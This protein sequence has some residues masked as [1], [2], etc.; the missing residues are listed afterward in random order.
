VISGFVLVDKPGGWTSHDVVGK[1]RRL[2]GQKKVGHA[3]TL[4]PMATGLVVVGLGACTRLM[5]YVQDQPKTYEAT[6]RFGVATDS[7]DADGTEVERHPMPVS[8]GDV[9]S[10]LDRF[11]GDIMQ[12]PPMVSAL[13]KDGRRLH[14]L[15]REGKVVE[16]RPRPVTIHDLELTG[17]VEGDYPD[18]SFR[19]TCGSGTYV[20]S[21][22]DDIAAEL[23]GRAHLIALRRV[24]NGGH[25]VAAAHT[26]D[27]LEAA[28][29][30]STVVVRAADG[31]VELPSIELDAE[32][33]AAV[34][35]GVRIPAGSLGW[36]PL[37]AGPVKMVWE[38]SLR[39]VY[40][41]DGATL[42][43]EVVVPITVET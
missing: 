30:F 9:E 38:G 3:G 25:E 19:V 27:E 17:L 12:V 32:T 28:D 35:N 40:R 29:P 14:E 37:D 16:R 31:L 21:L 5:R 42:R 36:D 2:A 33:A 1:I 13:K 24:R 4:D 8:A 18:V 20:R 6:A 22:A 43:P 26:I 39:A 23:G 41:C 34:G 10:V 7:L 11:R 15:A